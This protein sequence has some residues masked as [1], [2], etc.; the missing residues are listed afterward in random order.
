MNH[1]TCGFIVFGLLALPP[2]S[3]LTT[4]PSPQPLPQ[5]PGNIFLAG[6]PVTVNLPAPRTNRWV[7]YNYEEEKLAEFPPGGEDALRL[8]ALPVGFYQV[9]ASNARPITLGVLAPLAHPTPTNSPIGLDVAMAWFYATNQM[10]AVANLCALAGI[11]WVRDRLNWGEMEPRREQFAGPN[12]YDASARAQAQAGLRVLQVNHSSPRWANPDGRRFPLDL[13]EAYRFYREMARRWHG[14]VL[15]FE[16]WNEADIT[17]FG[18]H[19]GSE[20]AALQ[21]AAYLGLKAGNPAVIACLNVFALPNK[22]QLAD[23][24]DNQ[25]WPYFETFNLHHYAQ[26][27]EYPRIYAAFRAVSAGRPLWVTECS[28]PVQWSGDE[29][30]KEP[31]DAA[32]RTQAERVAKTFA[33]SL[34]EGSVATYYFLLPHYS[35]GKTQFGVLH[36]DLTPRPAFVALAA[37][38][39][40]L[41]VARP[42]GR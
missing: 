1:L 10:D 41:A 4:R 38:G 27:D 23:L 21:K 35:E 16:P 14:Q 19:T 6:E 33:A 42:L 29:K 3:A 37:A 18:G 24:N 25:A 20:M 32:L 9:R 15:A 30:L 34:H 12:R 26:F 5:H 13:R 17:M 40:L 8:G 7:L 31:T 28:L 39:R 22:A 36:A 11:N 2:A